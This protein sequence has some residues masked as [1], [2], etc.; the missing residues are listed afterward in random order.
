MDV[1]PALRK[2]V[3]VL[4]KKRRTIHSGADV[5]LK[6]HYKGFV[7]IRTGLKD[8]EVTLLSGIDSRAITCIQLHIFE[9]YILHTFRFHAFR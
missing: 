6:K 2:T 9:F 7:L 3:G 4:K 5:Y 1:P 8:D